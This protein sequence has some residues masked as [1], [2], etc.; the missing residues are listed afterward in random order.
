MGVSLAFSSMYP[1]TNVHRNQ[2]ALGL[3][4]LDCMYVQRWLLFIFL[5]SLKLSP[6]PYNLNWPIFKYSD[7]FFLFLFLVC[8]NL[9]LSINQLL[10][11]CSVIVQNC[12]SVLFIIVSLLIFSAQLDT[13]LMLSC[14]TEFASSE[15]FSDS[16]KSYICLCQEMFHLFYM[17]FACLYICVLCAWYLRKL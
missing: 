16:L 13:V 1:V 4:E 14:I 8:L 15:H 10:F 11:L 6:K 9:L 7:P 12:C 17:C 2:K 5:C 3:L